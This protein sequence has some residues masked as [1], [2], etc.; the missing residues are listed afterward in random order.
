MVFGTVVMTENPTPLAAAARF[1]EVRLDGKTC[2]EYLYLRKQI[3]A[4][5]G[6][7]DSDSH[8]NCKDSQAKLIRPLQ[9]Q[10]LGYMLLNEIDL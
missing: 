2:L 9:T 6:A 3:L 10:H 8:G 5:V 1:K 4:P 7:Q